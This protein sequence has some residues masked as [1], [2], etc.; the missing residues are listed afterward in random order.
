MFCACNKK[1]RQVSS[2]LIQMKSPIRFWRWTSY[3]SDQINWKVTDDDDPAQERRD[4]LPINTYCNSPSLPPSYLLWSTFRVVLLQW[5]PN[6]GGGGLEGVVTTEKLQQLKYS[7]FFWPHL[8]TSSTSIHQICYSEYYTNTW[9]FKKSFATLE[10][11]INL[12]RRHVH[13]FQVL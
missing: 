6:G 8:I 10:Y 13:C 11:Y 1:V 3:R 7:T 12:F 2:S 4:G 9:C 5:F